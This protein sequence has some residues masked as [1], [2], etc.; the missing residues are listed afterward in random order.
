MEKIERYVQGTIHTNGCNLEC[1]YCYLK[2]QG[3]KAHGADF[4]YDL[5]H[6]RK[7]MS[8]ER[9]GCCF[10]SLTGDGE[11]LMDVRV[12]ELAR[13]LLEEG[14]FLNIINNGTVTK[15][16]K[17]MAESF[18]EDQRH[19][20]MLTFSLHYN[21][22]KRKN[23]LDLYFENVRM[24]R[25]AG[26]TIYL[27]L[28]LADEY[29]AIADEIRDRC[30]KE[31]GVWPQ[32][33]I[34]R[35]EQD[36]NDRSV[37]SGLSEEEYFAAAE[38]FESPYFE[39]QRALYKDRCVDEYCYA[40]DLGVLLNFSTGYMNQCMCNYEEY[41]NVFENLNERVRFKRVGNNCKAPWCFCAPFQ[42]L[43]MQPGKQYKSYSDIYAGERAQL[44]SKE[45]LYALDVKLADAVFERE[46]AK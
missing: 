1:S 23:L 5:E 33:G 40:G 32:I 34:V 43:G 46:Q 36:E 8:K 41:Y 31:L 28:V 44:A 22:L 13:M 11:T 35:A 37:F 17:Y 25:D 42:I 2:L 14:H 6:M 3:N 27:H 18:S 20:T 16:L 38:R 39:L 4:A 45:M 26:F 24:M 30:M 29:I 15:N 10:I 21:E 9:F 7:A 12:V 19:R